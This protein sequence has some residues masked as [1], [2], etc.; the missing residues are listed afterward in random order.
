MQR[1][2]PNLIDAYLEFTHGHEST[3]RIRKWSI[4]SIIAASMERKC[5]I[6]RGYYTLFPNLYT[7]I[8]GKSGL[9]KK[10]TSTGIAVNLFRELENVRVMSDRM[11][12]SAV[13]EQLLLSGKKYNDGTKFV[14][15][16]A[17]FAY[18]SELSVFLEEVFGDISTLLTT[19]YDCVP[20]DS[21]KP[22]TYHTIGRGERKVFGPCLNILGASTKAWLKKCI[23][24]SEMEGGFTSRIV[25]VVENSLPDKLIPW[26]E[27]TASHDEMRVKI[28][29]DLKQI[30]ALTGPFSVTPEAKSLF[31]AWYEHHMRQVLPFN[32]DPRM[33][34][35][36]SR[37]GDTILKIAMS[38]S[39]CK[40]NSLTIEKDDL[41]WASEEIDS[42]EGDW[43][44]A[45]DG[46][47][48]KASITYEILDFIRK[49][50]A[51]KRTVVIST[52]S[53]LYQNSEVQKACSE[54]VEMEEVEI[55]MKKEGDNEIEYYCT[56]GIAAI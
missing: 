5:F 22:W 2:F 51:V 35:Y 37:K 41:I 25:F 32:Q 13:I 52:F 49:K 11:T 31:S 44:L 27:L 16:S 4:I 45:F 10:S 47:G 3:Q 42:L 9:I 18:A 39:V 46:L 50:I 12:A 14:N 20:H 30:H 1:N 56:P 54:L 43:R 26:P 38:R 36:M 28:V 29:A 6:P 17:L 48:V 33:V 40:S 21:T 7:F 55:R 23:P 53:Q 15:Q 19:F 24:R 34:G 8:I